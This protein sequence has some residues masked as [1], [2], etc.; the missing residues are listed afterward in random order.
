MSS[1]SIFS[2]RLLS[3][4]VIERSKP[5]VFARASSRP[6]PSHAGLSEHSAIYCCGR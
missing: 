3:F 5:D 4:S 2:R 1:A 6:G